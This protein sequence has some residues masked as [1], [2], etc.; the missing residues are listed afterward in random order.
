MRTSDF[1]KQIENG[2]AKVLTVEAA[3]NLKGKKI[4]YAY[5]GIIRHRWK[6]WSSGI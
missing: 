1:I 6:K 5:L 4:I 2:N 3:R